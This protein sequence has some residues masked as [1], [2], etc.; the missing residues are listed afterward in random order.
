MAIEHKT[1]SIYVVQFHQ[2]T[3]LPVLGT[4]LLGNFVNEINNI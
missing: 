1:L 2:K 4:D 3:I